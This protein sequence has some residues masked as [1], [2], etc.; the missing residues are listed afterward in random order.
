MI[1]VQCS[2]ISDVPRDML[3]PTSCCTT[4]S[5]IPIWYSLSFQ[6]TMKYVICT[7]RWWTC[8][9]VNTVKITLFRVCEISGQDRVIGVRRNL[10][11]VI[12]ESRRRMYA[13]FR[14]GSHASSPNSEIWRTYEN[15]HTIDL[16]EKCKHT[17]FVL[18][19]RYAS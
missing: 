15:L 1:I 18:F 11:H 17:R 3:V 7:S 12:D 2:S 13:V 16:L 19:W 5:I 6:M 10:G 14:F 8:P 4:I 9:N